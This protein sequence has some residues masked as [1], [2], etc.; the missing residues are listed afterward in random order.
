MRRLSLEVLLAATAVLSCTHG[1]HPAPQPSNP[2]PRIVGYLASWGVRSKGTRIADLPGD[3]LTH[4]IYAFARIPEDGGCALAAPCLDVGQCTA[5]PDAPL[6][7][8]DRGNFAEL[9]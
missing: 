9:R 3:Q 5:P 7:S 2:S 1:S 6:P 4:I 8:T